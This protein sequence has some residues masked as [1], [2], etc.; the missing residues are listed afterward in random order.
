MNEHDNDT[1]YWITHPA[2]EH[3]RQLQAAGEGPWIALAIVLS[4]GLAFLGLLGFFTR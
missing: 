3:D 1:D 4:G 2:L